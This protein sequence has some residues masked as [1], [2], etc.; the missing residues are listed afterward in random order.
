MS[1]SKFLPICMQVLLETEHRLKWTE[2]LNTGEAYGNSE[3]N[4][5]ISIRI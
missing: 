3:Q 4:N 5:S 1:E 2:R